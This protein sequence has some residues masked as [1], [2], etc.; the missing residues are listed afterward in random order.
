MGRVG[1][2]QRLGGRYLVQE[3]VADG[4]MA[5]VWKAHDEVLARPVAIKTLR[6]QM[7]GKAEFRK[8]FHA[9]AVA[10]ARLNH[11]AIISIFDTGIDGRTAFIVM[12]YFEGRTLADLLRERGP[13]DGPTAIGL[14]LPVLDALA[15]AHRAGVVHRDVKPANILVGD[16]GRVKVADFG[17]AK[18]LAGHDL[19][20]TGKVL[21]TVRYL[22]PEQVG[23][24]GVDPRS[25]L[26]SVGVV[27]YE[28]VT[29]RPPFQAET[30]IATAMMRLTAD[31]TPPRSVVPGLP[32]SIEA[33]ILRA[34]A[35]SPEDRFQ[36]AESMRGALERWAVADGPTRSEPPAGDGRTGSKDGSMFRSW[37]LVPL[38][39]VVVAV[40]AIVAAAVGR[41]EL[42]GIGSEEPTRGTSAVARVTIDGSRDFDPFGTDGG[43][44]S[45]EA[46]LATDGDPSTAWSTEHYTT[47]DFGGLKPALGLFVDLDA[48]RAVSRVMVTSGL[49]GWR[50]RLLPGARPDPDADP[51]Q[52]VDGSTTFTVP[53]SGR[54]EILLRPA[55]IQ[56]LMIWIIQLAPDPG[57]GGEFAADVREVAISGPRR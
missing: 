37:M 19:T 21:G 39:L 55:R 16:A 24:G 2:N 6:E 41:L 7:A 46:A 5:T 9:E 48:D 10:A 34:M 30:D 17:I 25:D 52:A 57:R 54:I 49:T 28:L 43:E 45:D 1:L 50:F 18:A 38:L 56:G 23:D 11:P 15:Y 40:A 44:N 33:A 26:Y 32:R 29:G 3:H 53:P 4:G 36:S 31:P 27:L 22:S 12:E 42:P 51:L 14:I 13:L 20:T 8:R 47:A 35:R